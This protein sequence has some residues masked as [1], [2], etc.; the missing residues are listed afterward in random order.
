M[1]SFFL[2]NRAGGLNTFSGTKRTFKIHSSSWDSP[3]CSNEFVLVVGVLPSPE[4]VTHYSSS[5]KLSSE[6]GCSAAD[7]PGCA[8]FQG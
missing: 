6:E 2:W 7:S 3:T 4:I 1:V 5:G 8:E